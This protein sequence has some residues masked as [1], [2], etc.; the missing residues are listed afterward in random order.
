MTEM[1]AT[2]VLTLPSMAR[3]RRPI[4][5]ARNRRKTLPAPIEPEDGQAARI[6]TDALWIEQVT[7]A[8]AA[9]A[10]GRDE[11]WIQGVAD[12]TVDPTLDEL[13]VAL[14][15]IGLETRIA[16]GL[17]DRPWPPVPHDR[18]RVAEKIRRH[19]TLDMDMYGRVWIRRSPPQPGAT[20][21]LFGAGPGREDG[22]GWAAIL[23]RNVLHAL[24]ATPKG[25]ARCARISV[26]QAE[27]LAVGQWRPRSGAFEGILAEVG[28]PMVIR[29]EEY[30][31]DDDDEHAAWEADPEGYE[32]DIAA[33]RA[34]FQSLR[35]SPQ[36]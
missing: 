12:G 15:A 23:T 4:R 8:Q 11:T 1:M 18:G 25:L 27:S 31:E 34:E 6:M 30:C 17:P 28:V 5:S 7:A 19:R 26:Q 3:K 16:L 10:S 32:S 33:L 35:P 24:D 36:T 14:N 13:E 9:Q 21:R 20:A 22:G 2:A 29:I